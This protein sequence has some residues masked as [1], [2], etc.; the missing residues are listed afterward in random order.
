MQ[1]VRVLNPGYRV[2]ALLQGRRDC[3]N[4][5]DGAGEPLFVV[6]PIDELSQI[7]LLQ[8]IISGPLAEELSRD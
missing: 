8:A 4:L 6:L 7:V 2:H 3:D 5:H 1:P